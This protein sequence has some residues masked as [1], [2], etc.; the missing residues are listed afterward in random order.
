MYMSKIASQKPDKQQMFDEKIL[1]YCQSYSNW[2]V[3]NYKIIELSGFSI[4]FC[5]AVAVVVTDVTS[6]G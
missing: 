6:K 1:L 4:E 5:T 2:N 3:H